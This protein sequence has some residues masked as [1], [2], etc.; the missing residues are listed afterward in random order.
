MRVA[1]VLQSS[2][3]SA[4]YLGEFAQILP[5][6][7]KC[8]YWWENSGIATPQRVTAQISIKSEIERRH[9]IKMKFSQR[10]AT[11]IQR[12]GGHHLPKT[13]STID[14]GSTSMYRM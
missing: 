3:R 8:G 5:S 13:L 14:R 2:L 9:V 10:G 6:T 4:S 7:K 1:A 12:G 11:A